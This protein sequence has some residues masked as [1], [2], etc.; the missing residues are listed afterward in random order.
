M[1]SQPGERSA[2]E[3][4]IEA[5]LPLYQTHLQSGGRQSYY[6]PYDWVIQRLAGAVRGV[7]IWAKMPIKRRWDRSEVK[8]AFPEYSGLKL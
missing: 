7:V 8:Q 2:R 3:D 4:V 6:S 1:G 5:M